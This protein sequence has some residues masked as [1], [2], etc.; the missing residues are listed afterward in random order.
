MWS[1][2]ARS[3]SPHAAKLNAR[4]KSYG[5]VRRSLEVVL[6]RYPAAEIESRRCIR[7]CLRSREPACHRRCSSAGLISSQPSARWSWLSH[8]TKLQQ[9][10][11]LP[12]FSL[13]LSRLAGWVTKRFRC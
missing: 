8:A 4:A 5:E 2:Y 9:L 11:L 6:G 3:S 12:R 7:L 1:T 10:A 13:S